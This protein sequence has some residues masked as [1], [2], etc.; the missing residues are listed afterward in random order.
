MAPVGRWLQ[1]EMTLVTDNPLRSPALQ[2][3]TVETRSRPMVVAG[4]RPRL[5]AMTNGSVTRSSVEYTWEDPAALRGL[6]A[7]FELDR[8]VETATTEFETQLR[9][10]HWAY[11]IPIDRLDPHA[12]RY[13]DLP[14]LER[15]EDGG[16]CL[17]GPYDEPRRQG[18]CLFCN[19]T[20]IAALLSFG[21]AARWVNIST[22]HTYGHEVTEVWSNDFDK[23]VFL[24]ATR[25]Y[26]MVDPDSGVPLSLRQIGERVGEILPAPVTWDRPIPAQMP[27]GVSPAN[28]R[29]AY[30]QPSHGGPVFIDGADHDL[31]M[32]GHLQMPLRNDFVTRPTPVPWRISS[33]WGSSEFYCWSSRMFPPKLEYAH[34]TNR[35][36][37]WEPPLNRVQLTLSETSERGVLRVDADT[38]TPWWEVFELCIDGGAWQTQSKSTWSWPLHEGA[39]RLRV[40]V[41]NQLGVRGPESDAEVILSA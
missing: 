1:F 30:R 32:I 28:V 9:L 41:R 37:D 38:V 25:D 34:G 39:N 29:V 8:V 14:Q 21:Y 2:A 16:I 17:L 10:M 4:P 23:W 20:L 7:R 22:K 40:R 5:L 12:W 26:Y 33:N 31:L 13:E 11:R 24:D 18:H 15:D 19:F 27:Q 36:Q 35:H 6:R 3:V